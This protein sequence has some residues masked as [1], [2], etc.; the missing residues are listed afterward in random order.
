[1]QRRASLLLGLGLALASV[2]CGDDETNGTGGA[3]GSGGSGSTTT[4]STT[5]TTSSTGGDGGG[6]GSTTGEG[7]AGGGQG[8]EGGQGGGIPIARGTF[9]L[10]WTLAIADEEAD[11][12]ALGAEWV[13]VGARPAGTDGPITTTRLTCGDLGGETDELF[14]G[15][16]DITVSLLSFD[17]ELVLPPVELTGE[18]VEDGGVVTLDP[19]V[20]AM[21]GARFDIGW[22]IVDG[23]Q[24]A[25]CEAAGAN[26]MDVILMNTETLITYGVAFPCA[27]GTGTSRALPLG[28]Y[29]VAPAL[30][31]FDVVLYS[32]EVFEAELAEAGAVERMPQIVFDIASPQ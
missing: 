23:D 12:F 19:I 2:A 25:T 26:T 28:T 20:W 22:I 17:E 30:L 9:E 11:C 8:G 10:S 3:G 27:D 6:G 15:A 13:D 14:L 18:L 31:D 5:T 1:M 32:A 21:E 24:D 16:Y 7:G 29:E 4:T